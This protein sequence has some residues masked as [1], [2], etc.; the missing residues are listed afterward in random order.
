MRRKLPEAH[1]IDHQRR[2][3]DDREIGEHGARPGHGARPL[4]SERHAISDNKEIGRPHAEHDQRVPVDPVGQP[5]QRPTGLILLDG[6]RIDVADTPAVEIAGTC[7]VQGVRLTP[8]VIGCQRDYAEDAADPVIDTPRREH[9]PVA[10]I[11]LD[12]EQ[13]HHEARRWN[14]QQ[15]GQPETELRQDRHQNPQGHKGNCGDC[16]FEDG[17][18]VAGMAIGREP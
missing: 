10:A 2:Q 13:A 9:R 3:G 5:A 16:D 8:E 17:A 14:R 4:H 6:Q 15:Q 11:M 1:Q 18:A 12:H 7:M